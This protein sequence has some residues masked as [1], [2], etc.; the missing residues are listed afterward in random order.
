MYTFQRQPTQSSQRKAASNPVANM[1]GPANGLLKQSKQVA[2]QYARQSIIDNSSQVKQLTA[3]Q[4]MAMGTENNGNT[5]SHIFQGETI[6]LAFGF[7]MESNNQYVVPKE[8]GADLPEKRDALI[9]ARSRLMELQAENAGE[10]R[11]V[12]F[13]TKEGGLDSPAEMEQAMLEFAAIAAK[14][15][16]IPQFGSMSTDELGN[17]VANT[18]GREDMVIHDQHPEDKEKYGLS[19]YAE[20]KAAMGGFLQSTIGVPLDKFPE[21]FALLSQSPHMDESYKELYKGLEPAQDTGLSKDGEGLV[22]MLKHI[23]KGGRQEKKDAQFPKAMVGVMNRTNMHTMFKLLPDL[24]SYKDDVVTGMLL[25]AVGFDPA[26]RIFNQTFKIR[27][28]EED[29]YTIDL[30]IGE[31]ISNLPER[32]LLA[33]EGKNFGH[34]EEKIDIIKG[35]KA[36]IVELRGI[37]TSLPPITGADSMAKWLNQAYSI[38]GIYEEVNELPQT[39]PDAYIGR[40]LSQ[41]Y[42]EPSAQLA[43][44]KLRGREQTATTE[45]ERGLSKGTIVGVIAVLAVA[46]SAAV[47]WNSGTGDVLKE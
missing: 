1:A 39:D 42:D 15:N 27:D 21:L 46:V 2:D 40:I 16:E 25:Q 23:I 47:W 11:N 8:E 3:F 6:Q 31:W 19:P 32:D 30:T 26:E 45:P 35:K 24:D 13:A 34:L 4:R 7:E 43:M 12:E 33:E 14:M 41:V 37:A 22:A 28:K 20:N 44:D 9:T 38:M 18:E 29:P 10:R 5:L 17:T 36:P